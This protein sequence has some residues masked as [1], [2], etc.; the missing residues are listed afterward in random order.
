MNKSTEKLIKSNVIIEYQILNAAGFIQFG[1]RSILL[2]FL[3]F[4]M[5]MNN[6]NEIKI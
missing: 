2:F 1:K 3:V 6:K 5:M 4:W